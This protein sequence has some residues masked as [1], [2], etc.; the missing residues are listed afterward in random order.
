MRNLWPGVS[1]DDTTLVGSKRLVCYDFNVYVKSHRKVK[2]VRGV[3]LRLY[4]Y[5]RLLSVSWPCKAT[6][7]QRHNSSVH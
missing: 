6:L 7:Y 2:V 4:N 3:P 1:T 5:L